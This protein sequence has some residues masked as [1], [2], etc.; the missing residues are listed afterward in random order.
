MD[1]PGE[2]AGHGHVWPRPD[3]MKARCG[4]PALCSACRHDQARAQKLVSAP[5]DVPAGLVIRP[6]D[7][8]LLA[9]D[10]DTPQKQLG[11]VRD[12]LRERF[13]E[14]EFTFVMGVSAIAKVEAS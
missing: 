6:G 2:N 13:P 14:V 9:L 5:S 7:R 8:V 3:G 1:G 11:L 12:G 10:L 4:G